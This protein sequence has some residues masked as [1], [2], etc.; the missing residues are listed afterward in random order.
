MGR[1]GCQRSGRHNCLSGLGWD[2]TRRA[3]RRPGDERSPLTPR[4]TVR[5]DFACAIAVANATPAAIT[6]RHYRRTVIAHP[7][8]NRQRLSFPP[9]HEPQRCGS[10][11]A[12]AAPSCP[13]G[14]AFMRAAGGAAGLQ[15][16]S[17]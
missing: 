2:R 17:N 3:D 10:H 5:E 9:R 15:H 13:N 14:A 1:E 7:E 8:W 6:T 11:R 16:A 12:A 4:K